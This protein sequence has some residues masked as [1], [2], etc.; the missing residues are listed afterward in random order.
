MSLYALYTAQK[1]ETGKFD[2]DGQP[3]MTIK[4][5]L[6]VTTNRDEIMDTLQNIGYDCQDMRDFSTIGGESGEY[7]YDIEK[8]GYYYKWTVV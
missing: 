7:S 1:V 5:N 3:E 6:M 4:T 8:Y 2:L